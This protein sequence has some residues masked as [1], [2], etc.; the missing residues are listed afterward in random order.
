MSIL[1]NDLKTLPNEIENIILKYKYQLLMNNVLQ[2]LTTIFD[3]CCCCNQNKPRFFNDTCD[4]CA[5]YICTDCYVIHNEEHDHDSSL[6]CTEC[7][8]ICFENFLRMK[9]D[10]DDINTIDWMNF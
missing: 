9:Y 5:G 6:L 8:V 7:H 2:E 10:Y 3:T 4:S 1:P